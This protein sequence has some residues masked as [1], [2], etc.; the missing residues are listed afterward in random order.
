[1]YRGVC[2]NE[3]NQRSSPSQCFFH[4]VFQFSIH[5]AILCSVILQTTFL[6]FL[7]YLF[8]YQVLSVLKGELEGKKRRNCDSVFC[9]CW[10]QFPGFSDTPRTNLSR[11]SQLYQPQKSNAP[12]SKNEFNAIESLSQLLGPDNSNSSLSSP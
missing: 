3:K 12:S 4:V 1:M 5:L 10:L 8:S 6:R 9:V 11:P 2:I 7:F